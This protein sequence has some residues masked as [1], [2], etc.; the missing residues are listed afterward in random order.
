MPETLL[1]LAQAQLRPLAAQGVPD[2]RRQRLRRLKVLR[3]VAAR[4]VAEPDQT[5][6]PVTLLQRHAEEG[7]QRQVA[8][9]RADAVGVGGG[10]VDDDARAILQHPPVDAVNRKPQRRLAHREAVI[11]LRC[12]RGVAGPAPIA[13]E[14]AVE[15][16]GGLIDLTDEADGA[17]GQLFGDFEGDARQFLLRGGAERLAEDEVDR[18]EDGVVAPDALLGEAPLGDVDRDADEAPVLQRPAGRAEPAVLPVGAAE[19]GLVGEAMALRK[20]LLEERKVSLGILGMQE[21]LPA[22]PRH[23][24]EADTEEVEIVVVD[25]DRAARIRVPDQDGCGIG[26][27]A[28][29]NVGL[30][31][32]LLRAGPLHRR[33]GAL[34]DLGG[35][36]DLRRGPFPRCRHG[37]RKCADEAALLR[38]RNAEQAHDTVGQ[39]PLPAV[40]RDQG[41]CLHVRDRDRLALAL[42]GHRPTD[43][44]EGIFPGSRGETCAREILCDDRETLRLVQVKVV[45]VV[46]LKVLAEQAAGHGLDF[47]RIG[48]GAQRVAE[49]EHEGLLLLALEQGPLDEDAIGRL[50]GREIEPG[51]ASRFVPQR[52]P[53][54]REPAEGSLR[55]RGKIPV[56]I[57]DLTGLPLSYRVDDSVAFRLWPDFR[58]RATKGRRIAEVVDRVKTVVIDYR[59]FRTPGDRGRQ[60]RAEHQLDHR[61]QTLRPISNGAKRCPCPIVGTNTRGHSR[62]G[63]PVAAYSTH[64]YVKDM[65]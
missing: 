53:L 58:E 3:P 37:E 12:V 23:G 32:R 5:P 35:Q 36:R 38:Q 20:R 28:Q 33:P 21:L 4:A 54:G 8:G 15:A 65:L 42:M 17:A 1:A 47:E 62:T 27:G 6:R 51:E 46:R 60:R 10:I 43:E 24:L 52:R 55:P 26:Q 19:P 49:A 64:P 18:L 59:K 39:H 14:Q 44:A 45:R 30:A 48:Q 40:V 22:I 25:E 50:E 41:G 29:A 31:R 2:R 61:P 34:A 11:P 9:R 13:E 16:P 63:W 56:A 57:N 7:R